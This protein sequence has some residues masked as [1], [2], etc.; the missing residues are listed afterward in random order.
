MLLFGCGWIAVP[1]A[2]ALSILDWGR[3]DSEPE[4]GGN[5]P[6]LLLPYICLLGALVSLATALVLTRTLRGSR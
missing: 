2:G 3:Q 4:P 6:S 5:E 1:L